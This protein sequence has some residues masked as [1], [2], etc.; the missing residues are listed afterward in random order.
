M[1]KGI[2]GTIIDLQLW[3]VELGRQ[4]HSRTLVVKGESVIL[5]MLSRFMGVFPFMALFTSSS[6]FLMFLI[7]WSLSCVDCSVCSEVSLPLLFSG[8]LASS[9]LRL[10]LHRGREVLLPSR[11]TWHLKS[12]FCFISSC[13]LAVNTWIYWAITIGSGGA[14]VVKSIGF[15]EHCR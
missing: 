8:L 9:S 1:V 2:F 4:G 15:K 12:S 3:E 13:T 5:I 6:S 7:I 14:V 11:R 10:W